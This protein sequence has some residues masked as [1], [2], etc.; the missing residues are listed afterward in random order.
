MVIMMNNRIPINYINDQL[1]ENIRENAVEVGNYVKEHSDTGWLKKYAS[2]QLF[3]EKKFYIPDFKLYVSEDGDYSKVDFSNSVI[4][5]EALKEL[6]RYVLTNENFWVWLELTK[7]YDVCR[8][9]MP[10]KSKSTFKEHWLFKGGNRRGIFFGVL[11]RCY[12]KTELTVDDRLADKY[13]L[14]KFICDKYERFR[15]LSWRGISSEKHF[16]LGV[17][18]AEK[19]L[20]DE[21]NQ[22]PEK[23]EM[24]R[25][26]ETGLK[27]PERNLYTELAKELSLYGS[28]RLIDALSEDEIYQIAKEKM[29]LIIQ[30]FN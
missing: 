27:N 2:G 3:E 28:V 10:I 5:Y 1:L 18:K 30:K 15:N 4:L 26:A 9:A 16:V 17:I 14:T 11:S 20:Y 7:C 22:T 29:I 8:Q 12:F 24:F 21:Y 13:E 6:P 25:K 19:D 23:A